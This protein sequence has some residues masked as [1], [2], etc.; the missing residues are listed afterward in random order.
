[1]VCRQICCLFVLW[2]LSGLLVPAE[3]WGDDAV[4]VF[5]K[6]QSL[7]PVP[8]RGERFPLHTTPDAQG[9]V[10]EDGHEQAGAGQGVPHVRQDTERASA[11]AVQHNEEVKRIVALAPNLAALLDSLGAG[12]RLV[13]CAERSR[14]SGCGK[15]VEI[16]PYN[17]PVLERIVA[18]RPDLCLAAGDGTPPATVR[19]LRAMGMRVLVLQAD[20]FA[21]LDETLARL[22][23]VLGLEGQAARLRGSLATRLARVERAVASIAEAQRPV[24]LFQ[25]QASPPIFAGQDTFAGEL[26]RRAGGRN[27][28]STEKSYPCLNVEQ[29]LACNPDVVIVTEMARAGDAVALWKRFPQLRAVKAGR[30]H[31]VDADRFSQPALGSLDAL[32]ELVELLHPG[33]LRNMP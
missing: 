2:V 24:T 32:E 20:T 6:A 8:D 7:S 12:D 18:L 14:G 21:G 13:G 25:V 15:A 11:V 23:E 28:V 19:L 10:F 1:M 29:V 33:L 5:L 17:R 9:I 26:V 30:L 31:R 4:D 27:P 22:G 3:T 16:G